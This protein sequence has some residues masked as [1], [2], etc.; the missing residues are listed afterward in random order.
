MADL[1]TEATRLAVLQ[2][3]RTPV[4]STVDPDDALLPPTALDSGVPLQSA[5]RAMVHVSLRENIAFRTVRLTIPTPDYTGNYGLEFDFGAGT[6]NVSYDPTGDV[7][8][9]NLV[10]GIAAAIEAEGDVNGFVDA[11]AVA[12]SGTGP[13]DTVVITGKYEAGFAFGEPTQVGDGAVFAAVADPNTADMTLWWFAGA[14]A[15]STPPALWA[16]DGEVRE[17]DRKGWVER[18]DVA[19]LDRLHVQVSNIA[20]DAGDWVEM[21]YTDPVISVGPCLSEIG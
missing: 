21:T 17:L 9:A 4:W 8:V 18:L 5:V 10:D 7:S 3:G 15:G 13:H 19:G 11:V 14:R 2:A 16:S 6:V 1:Y 12:A 20:G